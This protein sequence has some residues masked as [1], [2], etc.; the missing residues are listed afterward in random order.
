MAGFLLPSKLGFF[1]I[2]YENADGP[3]RFQQPRRTPNVITFKTIEDISKPPENHPAYTTV[4]DL[5]DRLITE[6]TTPGQ[7]YDHEVYGYVILIEQRRHRQG[8]R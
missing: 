2:L 5:V 6:Y 1:G 4:K 7:P 8:T 3:L